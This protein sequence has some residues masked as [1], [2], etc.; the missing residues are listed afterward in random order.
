MDNLE[1]LSLE[2]KKLL[3][4]K[5]LSKILKTKNMMRNHC[6]DA[7]N[8]TSFTHHKKRLSPADTLILNAIQSKNDV[9]QD[10]ERKYG[11]TLDWLESL[12]SRINDSIE[13]SK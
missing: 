11:P 1:S 13:S 7:M 8:M 3:K 12:L 6:N 9:L 5:V 2:D 4:R 10:T